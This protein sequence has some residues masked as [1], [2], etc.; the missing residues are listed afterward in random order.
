MLENL[1]EKTAAMLQRLIGSPEGQAVVRQQAERQEHEERATRAALVARFHEAETAERT[2]QTETAARLR[3]LQEREA[4]AEAA[5]R[6]AREA[7]LEL[8][9]TS[10]AAVSAAG[11][12]VDRLRA[13]VVAT[14]SPVIAECQA[15]LRELVTAAHGERDAVRERTI[16]GGLRTVWHNEASVNRRQEALIAAVRALDAWKLEALTP[17]DV[18]ARFEALLATLP[19]IERR[20]RGEY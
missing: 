16:D 6:T 8:E 20:P 18:R 11:W 7:R 1:T 9:A 4:R 19:T 15:E 10:R 17:A 2:A 14:A 12:T 13:E 5:W 3:P